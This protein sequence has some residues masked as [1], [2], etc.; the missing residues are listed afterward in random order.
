MNPATHFKTPLGRK[1]GLCDL[2]NII[3]WILKL[4]AYSVQDIQSMSKLSK[5]ESEASLFFN[6]FRDSLQYGSFSDLNTSVYFYSYLK[7][8]FGESYM[9]NLTFG[10]KTSAPL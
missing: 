10:D 3:A 9:I 8:A 7:M 6:G 5:Q 2:A 1:N 4:L